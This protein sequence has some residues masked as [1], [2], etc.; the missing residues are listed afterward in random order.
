MINPNAS[1]EEIRKIAI[2]NITA[3][4]TNY[5]DVIA[6]KEMET[7]NELILENER[8]QQELQAQEELIKS[9]LM[10][11]QNP[12]SYQQQVIPNVPDMNMAN[13]VIQGNPQMNVPPMQNGMNQ[14]Y[15]N[16]GM[17]NQGFVPNVPDMNMMNGVIPQ[18]QQ[19]S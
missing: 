5:V 2:D 14:M 17:I 8:K 10:G 1:L 4:V 13:G 16:Q 15:P 12:Y 9:K 7:V 18:D 3:I 11:M 6:Q 19:N